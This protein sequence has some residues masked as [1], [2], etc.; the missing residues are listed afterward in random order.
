MFNNV[1]EFKRFLKVGVK[2]KATLHKGFAGRDDEGKV[3]YCDRDLGIRPVSI[4]QTNSFAFKTVN[5]KGEVVD[6]WCHF[7]AASDAK[8]ENG[9]IT[10]YE[11]DCRKFPEGL[12]EEGN[13]D[14]DNLPEI[15]VL[16][17]EI[18]K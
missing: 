8:V 12:M 3:I 4:V 9:K 14:Y 17:Y 1:A 7:P 2:L 16:T 6:S 11:K 13:P 18:V 5:S 10:I 15:P